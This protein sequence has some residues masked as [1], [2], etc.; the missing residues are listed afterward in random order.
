MTN[1]VIS[2]AGRQSKTA[3]APEILAQGIS[4][5]SSDLPLGL[6]WCNL[7]YLLFLMHYHPCASTRC[8][9]LR[10]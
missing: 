7:V 2:P 4:H 9:N 10:M 3:L 5:T 1:D 6:V 8:P